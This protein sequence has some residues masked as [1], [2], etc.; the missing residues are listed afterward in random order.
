VRA[1]DYDVIYTRWAQSLSPGNEQRYFWGST[2]V[3]DEG[4]NNYAGI[5]K[6]G[7]DALI[8]RIV[9]TPD[10]DYLVAVTH[11][12]DRVLLETHDVVPSYTI[13]YAR[14]ARW[15][16]FSHPETLP[17]FAI[18]FPDIWWWD[19]DKAAATGGNSR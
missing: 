10:R 1:F 9:G 3:D 14:T 19:E 12:L 17:E 8:H 15:D 13:T 11:A 2:S 6:P 7:T 5:S 16:R 18:G 4:S